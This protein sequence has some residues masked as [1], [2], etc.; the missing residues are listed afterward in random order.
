MPAFGEKS[1]K[2]LSTCH[3]DLQKLFNEVIKHIDCAVLEGHRGEEAQEEAVRTGKSKVHW[4]NG[5]HNKKPSLAADVAPWPI[6]WNDK[7]RFYYFAGFVKG[8]AATMGLTIRWGGDWDSDND[9]K[10]QTFHDL[11]HFELKL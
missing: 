8:I 1:L 9:F 4:P 10:D 7:D 6:D 5:N 3:E 11:P 2:Q